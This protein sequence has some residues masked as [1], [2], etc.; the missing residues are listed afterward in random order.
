MTDKEKAIVTAYTGVCMLAGNK[1]QIFHKYI[2]DL[3]ERPVFTHEIGFLADTIKE[4]SKADFIALCRE[5]SEDEDAVSRNAIIQTL[6]NMDR[7][8]ANEL[9]LCDTNNKFPQNEVFIVDDVYEQIAEQL[10]SVTP[11]PKTRRCKDCK[12][13]K[14]NDG[15]YRRG[16]RDD[17][18]P[19]NRREVFEGN[20]Y[21]YI[22]EPKTE[23][24]G[25]ND[26]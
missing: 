6:N 4:K 18:C 3:M 19:I 20:G 22:F 15:F 16:G 23:E 14:D 26:T 7:Y 21:C 13:W 17:K 11:Q 12:W 2:E 9:I 24:V 5:E 1:F 25:E 8:V 10:P